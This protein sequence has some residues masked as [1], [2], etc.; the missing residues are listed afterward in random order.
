MKEV[1]TLLKVEGLSKHF[2]VRGGMLNRE[3][4]Q[5]KAV[6]GVSFGIPRGK[7]LGLVGESG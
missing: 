2:P 1:N 3:I 7:T 6:D 4:G 5:I